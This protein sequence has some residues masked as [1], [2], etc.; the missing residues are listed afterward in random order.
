MTVADPTGGIKVLLW[1]N[2]C[3]TD[4]LTGKTY[5]FKS[6]H[7]R[8]NNYGYYLNTPKDLLHSI[9]QFAH[10]TESLAES[11]PT[12]LKDIDAKL[13]LVLIETTNRYYLCSKCG[14]KICNSNEKMAR[15]SKCS[16]LN[17]L[18]NCTCKVY[19]KILSKNSKWEKILLSVYN[20]CVLQLLS[21]ANDSADILDLS[22]EKSNQ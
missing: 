6:F 10:F 17:K 4:I 20:D 15:C 7:F 16:S 19:M 11:D 18:K 1:G 13:S 8:S 12:E 9:E 14:S 22:E 3:E 21:L 5:V 2:A